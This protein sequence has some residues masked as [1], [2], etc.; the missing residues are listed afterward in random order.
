MPLTT[1]EKFKAYAGLTGTTNNDEKLDLI[2][3]G[4]SEQISQRCRRNFELT[5]YK[6]WMDGSGSNFLRLPQYPIVNL[7][8]VSTTTKSVMDVEFSGGTSASIS[9]TSTGV[10]LHSLSNTGVE[11]ETEILFADEATIG[12]LAVAIDAVTGWSVEIEPGES[13]EGSVLLRPFV[14]QWALNPD[15]AT[16]TVPDDGFGAQIAYDTEAMIE[17]RGFH[18][19]PKGR[20][21]IFV[22]Y[23]AGYTLPTDGAGIESGNVPEGL[24]LATN[25]MVR[26][27][28]DATKHD[29]SL[30]SERIGNYS[31]KLASSIVGGSAAVVN[32]ID[33][34]MAEL[35]PYVRRVV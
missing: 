14:G 23:K 19:F 4:I 9:V 11:T 24:E 7:Y 33:Q 30:E 13:E 6:Q 26:A 18:G 34:H 3:P 32:I 28:L 21:N 10:V 12:D 2:I 22:W 15:D 25:K 16:L 17:S 27:L 5:T 8:R 1:K 31:Y 35:Q 29:A 20:S